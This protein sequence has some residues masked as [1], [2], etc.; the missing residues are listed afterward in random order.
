M[1]ERPIIFN[2]AEVRAILDGRKT[3]MRRVIKPQPFEIP[4]LDRHENIESACFWRYGEEREDWP[5]PKDCP[6]GQ[7]GDRLWVRETWRASNPVAGWVDCQYK[8]G[9][10]RL[11]YLK[12]KEYKQAERFGMHRS[13][14]DKW[15]SPVLMP[16][17]ASRIM[18]EIIN[19]HVERLQD[20]SE[21]DALGEGIRRIPHG[22]DGDYFHF[23][24]TEA[25][26]QNWC[27]PDDAFRELWDKLYTKRS[28]GWDT[29]PWVW[30]IG[31]KQVEATR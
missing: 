1:K 27:F 9:M 23:S 11:V 3:M 20:I 31:F 13:I 8:A 24:R 10:N 21:E 22:M 25:D 19:V 16:R 4:Y 5:T 17:W 12:G 15:T 29:N 7:P 26:P 2:S 30:V 6:F 14:Q 28:Y 18:L